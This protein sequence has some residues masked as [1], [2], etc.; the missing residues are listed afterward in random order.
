MT[1]PIVELVG[2]ATVHSCHQEGGFR[3]LLLP[4]CVEYLIK[5]GCMHNFDGEAWGF[6]PLFEKMLMNIYK[7][8]H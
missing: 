6:N 4:D 7:M 2:V 5:K 3:L 1:T 8:Y